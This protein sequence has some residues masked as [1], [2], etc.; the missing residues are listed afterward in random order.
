LKE[1]L[2]LSAKHGLQREVLHCM[3]DG[4]VSDFLVKR[5]ARE[6]LCR[7][8]RDFVEVKDRKKNSRNENLKKKLE[9]NFTN[10]FF[11]VHP[12]KTREKK[13]KIWVA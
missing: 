6:I 12:K 3:S 4:S 2:L 1:V 8:S 11:E 10:N 7:K 13:L 9:I 5:K